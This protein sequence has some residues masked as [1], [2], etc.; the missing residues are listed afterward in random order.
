[1]PASDDVVW[2]TY[3]ALAARLGITSESARNLVRRR[4]WDRLDGNDGARRIGVPHEY[5][6]ER[7]DSPSPI[8]AN[9][10]PPS[11]G[12]IHASHDG[13][14]DRPDDRP[15]EGGMA[16]ALAVLERHIG[17]IEEDLARTREQ[18]V[19]IAAE[20][21]EARAA[22][23]QIDVLRAQLDSER[24]RTGA[25]EQDRDRWFSEARQDR[26]A[27]VTQAA[28]AQAEVEAAR[29]ELMAWKARPWWRRAFG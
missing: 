27:R 22:L 13:G 25:A 10:I 23:V 2:L 5:L 12:E 20:R 9:T 8:A 15:H 1:M 4:R 28:Q 6:S 21:D 26:E 19:V 24:V 7:D 17:R 16:M 29:A 11:D 14:D 3:D 18:I